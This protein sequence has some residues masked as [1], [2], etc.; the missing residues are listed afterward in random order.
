MSESR[1]IGRGKRSPA[2]QKYKNT[3]QRDR[4]KRLNVE[5]EGKRKAKYAERR[6]NFPRLRGSSRRARRAGI[7]RQGTDARTAWDLA[8]KA[9]D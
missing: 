7:P 9:G 8:H 5:A 6:K 1:K 2:R 4:N 3:M